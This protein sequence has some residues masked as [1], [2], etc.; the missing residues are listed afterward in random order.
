MKRCLACV[1]AGHSANAW[2]PCRAAAKKDGVFCVQH[3]RV[4]GGVILGICVNDVPDGV[5]W[6]RKPSL[7]DMP[8]TGKVPS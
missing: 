2:R 5:Q 3:E 1:V 8:V 4:I 7:A 6:R